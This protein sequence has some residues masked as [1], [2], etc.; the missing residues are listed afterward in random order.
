MLFT[1]AESS[2]STMQTIGKNINK[3]YNGKLI[4]DDVIKYKY[5]HVT[6]PLWG[7]TA[8]TGGFL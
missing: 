4:Y 2:Q 5:F 7:N 8:V 6:G 3:T 1:E